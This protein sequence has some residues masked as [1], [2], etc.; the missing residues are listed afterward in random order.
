MPSSSF[1]FKQFEIHQDR[2]AMKVG[3]DGVL[4]GA[5]VNIDSVENA[6]DIGTGTGLI[7]LMLAQRGVKCVDAVEIDNDAAKQA[8]E[9]VKTSFF[10]KNVNVENADFISFVST[11]NKKYDLIISN[12]PYFRN[13]FLS[14]VEKRNNARHTL[15]LDYSEIFKFSKE[16]LTVGGRVNLIFPFDVK[17]YVFSEAEKFGFFPNRQ[18]FV[19]PNADKP[20]KRCLIEFSEANFEPIVSEMYIEEKRRHY[21]SFSYVNLTRDFYLNIDKI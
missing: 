14:D 15:H 11:C 10:C 8:V 2:C 4:L 9:N 12:P 18:M 3:T 16:I 7:A 5:W 13:S 19:R 21:Y 1:K 17:D 6:L 20:I